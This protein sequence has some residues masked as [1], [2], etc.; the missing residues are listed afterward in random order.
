M[1]NSIFS[2][3]TFE[4][5]VFRLDGPRIEYTKAADESSRF[6]VELDNKI[7]YKYQFFSE[8]RESD[9]WSMLV[10]NT[11]E[12]LDAKF[13]IC[14]D[15]VAKTFYLR[16]TDE[17]DEYL[18]APA[19]AGFNYPLICSCLDAIDKITDY[20]SNINEE[21]YTKDEMIDE[22]IRVKNMYLDDIGIEGV[23]PSSTFSFHS[24]MK[25]GL[26]LDLDELDLSPSS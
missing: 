14:F 18:N 1:N 2:Q 20:F 23:N 4:L 9:T 5:A 3:L 24:N 25:R 16:K 19:E 12:A 22:C 15:G 8:P 26:D 17:F 13:V 11:D 6:T 21:C 7:R 10:R